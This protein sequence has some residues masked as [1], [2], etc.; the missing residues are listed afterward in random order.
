MEYYIQ[1]RN[2]GYLGNSPMW[3]GLNRNGYTADLNKAGKYSEEEAKGICTNNPEKNVAWPVDYIDNN[4]KGI[5]RVID[6]QHMDSNNVKN[7]DK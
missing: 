6:S 4:E 5:Q 1:N 7:F 2:A 3:W